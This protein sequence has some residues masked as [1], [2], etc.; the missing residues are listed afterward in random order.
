MIAAI[1]REQENTISTEIFF[2]F[3]YAA[4]L[5]KIPYWFSKSQKKKKKEKYLLLSSL[6][7]HIHFLKLC[8]SLSV[9]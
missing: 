2:Y 1:D 9:K 3:S 8:T 5:M 4:E 6:S 7:S